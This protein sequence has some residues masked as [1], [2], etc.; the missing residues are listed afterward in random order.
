MSRRFLRL[1]IVQLAFTAVP[2]E[3]IGGC[4]YFLPTCEQDGVRTPND[5][6]ETGPC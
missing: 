3:L 1:T 6:P 4:P 5:W 2:V